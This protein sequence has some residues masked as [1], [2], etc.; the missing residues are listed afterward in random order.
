MKNRTLSSVIIIILAVLVGWYVLSRDVNA[1][2][3]EPT[4]H[5]TAT[6]TDVTATTSPEAPKPSV[7]PKP[8]PKPTS[9][10]VVTP[11]PVQTPVEYT[12]IELASVT[13]ARVSEIIGL[14]NAE[15]TKAGLPALVES[16]RLDKAA[17]AKTDDEVAK[18]YF[19][20]ESP[21]GKGNYNVL[22]EE[23][24]YPY[25]YAGENLAV[26]YDSFEEAVEA[27]I[28]S[29]THRANILKAGYK[30]TGVGISIGDYTY[31]DD[32]GKVQVAHNVTY[33]AQYFGAR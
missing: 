32:R 8:A 6:S 17:Q 33:I 9:T 7:T 3:P 30:E 20:H 19:S 2:A 27:W 18:Q 13:D 11:K 14:V 5:I 28:N 21:D 10:P 29:P 23:A 4:E 24:G 26:K 31:T 1:P 15:R 25:S 22:I 16:G 12:D